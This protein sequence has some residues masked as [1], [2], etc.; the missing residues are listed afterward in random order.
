MDIINTK[1]CTCCNLE[2]EIDKFAFNK[3]RNHYHPQCRSCTNK[4]VNARRLIRYVTDEEYRLKEIAKSN[5]HFKE[6]R[7]ISNA[8]NRERRN[9]NKDEINK[10][11]REQRIL[12]ESYKEYMKEYRAKNKEHISLKTKE[13]QKIN[14]EKINS[15]RQIY[16]KNKLKNDINFKLQNTIRCRILIALKKQYKS[17][18]TIQL[19]G[20]SIQEARNHL[21]SQFTEGMSWENHGKGITKWNIDHIKPICSFDLTDPEN[22]KICFHYDNLRPLWAIDNLRKLHESDK[23]L[24]ISK[25]NC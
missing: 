23:F 25:I 8:K 6:N 22:Q 3:A 18:S 15:N 20:C 7:D 16:L 10:K 1:I 5:K 12:D 24:S 17:G 21:E 2:R 14:K 9:K 13:W 11:R 4:R 19:L